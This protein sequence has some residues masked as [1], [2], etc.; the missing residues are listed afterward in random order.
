VDHWVEQHM[1][2]LSH[3]RLAEIE[4]GVSEHHGLSHEGLLLTSLIPPGG[5]LVP[6]S[7]RTRDAAIRDLA[8][9]AEAAG[10]IYDPKE[11]IE[12]VRQREELCPTTVAPGIALPHPRHPM[13]YDI[14][15]SFVTVGRT[16]SGIP[17]GDPQGSLTRLLF[18]ICC[19]DDRTHLHVLARISR[20]L[21]EPTIQALLA[22]PD[23]DAL[24]QVLA[25][26]EKAVIA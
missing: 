24:R 22:A 19:K 4:Q 16:D 15:A 11:L 3:G 18:L 8:A 10:L 14:E 17:F 12:K 1:S 6:L 21:D 5:V 7:A 23:A 9:A 13:P 20:M 26:R 25:N 2:K